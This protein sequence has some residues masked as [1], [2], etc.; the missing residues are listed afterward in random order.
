MKYSLKFYI[1]IVVMK[2]RWSSVTLYHDEIFDEVLSLNCC[3]SLLMKMW[4]RFD[5]VLSLNCCESLLMK[6]WWRFDE[7]LSRYITMKYS[8][9]FY[10]KIVVMKIRWSSVT[11]YHDEVFVEVLYQ[12]C[13]DEDSMKFCHVISRWS[14]RWSSISKLLRW[15]SVT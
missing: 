7:V 1:K 9:K 13:C 4:W 10:I 5:E 8:L 11:L 2:I 3:E 6:M 12:N 14:I 15:R